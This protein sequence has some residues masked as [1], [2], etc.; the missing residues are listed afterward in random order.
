MQV[1]NPSTKPATGGFRF[2]GLGQF[3]RE[4]SLA[5]AERD[6][7]ALPLIQQ[8]AGT[9]DLR[10]MGSR[11]LRSQRRAAGRWGSSWPGGGAADG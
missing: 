2:E 3:L 4:G 10:L 9:V 6:S 1:A 5:A 11:R 7:A 8:S